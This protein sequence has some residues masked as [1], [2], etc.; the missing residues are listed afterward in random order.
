MPKTSFLYSLLL[1]LCTCC[2]IQKSS[3]GPLLHHLKQKIRCLCLLRGAEERYRHEGLA[4]WP[5]VGDGKSLQCNLHSWDPHGIRLR[6]NLCLK[7]YL[8][9]T[10][11]SSLTCFFCTLIGFSWEHILN[12]SPSLKF[13]LEDLLHPPCWH[14]WLKICHGAC[15]EL[16]WY[17][18]ELWSLGK[19][20]CWWWWWWVLVPA[21]L[22]CNYVTLDRV[23]T[24][25]FSSS[26]VKW[27][28]E[29][30]ATSR[31]IFWI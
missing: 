18:W 25:D 8:C 2:F 5:W 14:E 23:T 3:L 7:S 26:S 10:L 4:L 21:F 16:S 20:P 22:A 24:W 19:K 9:S 1:T 17:F 12:E 6:Q 29:G 15:Y 27:G 31:E 13:S 11:S 30:L 28:V